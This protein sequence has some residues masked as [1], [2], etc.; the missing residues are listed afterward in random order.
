MSIETELSV[1]KAIAF[2]AW[3]GC[4][5]G[6]YASERW[7][8]NCQAALDISGQWKARALHAEQMIHEVARLQ[9]AGE[10]VQVV[11]TEVLLASSTQITGVTTTQTSNTVH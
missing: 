7:R 5:A 2:F 8:K 9:A 6:I 10:Y 4:I 3:I 11:S 1:W